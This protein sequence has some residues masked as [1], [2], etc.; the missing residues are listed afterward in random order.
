MTS[1]PNANPN[2]PAPN[3]Q[4]SGNSLASRLNGNRQA[5]NQQQQ[6]T[7]QAAPQANNGATANN[8]SPFSG[9]S[10]PPRP[11]PPAPRF[12]AA[13]QNNN[14]RTWTMQPIQKTVVRFELRGLGDPFYR[15]LGHELNPEFGDFKKVTAL[16][17]KGGEAVREL[18]ATLNQTW[19]SYRLQGAMLVYNWNA[20]S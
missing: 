4:Q 13:A 12:G 18:E 2:P 1:V 15:L 17:E 3:Q 7:N 14:L 5:A 19:E 9:N 16:L 20:D 6:Q 10:A 11:A 8:N